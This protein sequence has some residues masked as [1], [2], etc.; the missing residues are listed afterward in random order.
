MTYC[1]RKSWEGL[2]NCPA[3]IVQANKLF[4]PFV[5]N[6][7]WFYTSKQLKLAM[8]WSWAQYVA[9]L[10]HSHPITAKIFECIRWQCDIVVMETLYFESN[11]MLRWLVLHPF[12]FVPSWRAPTCNECVIKARG[13]ALT[14]PLH[15]CRFSFQERHTCL[16]AKHFVGR[17]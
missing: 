16:Q 15:Y 8:P 14:I 10:Y 7:H 3:R 11:C 1:E 9:V 2:R 13:K 6:L 17:P 12:S 4:T 5:D